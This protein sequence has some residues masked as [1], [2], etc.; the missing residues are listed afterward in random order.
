LNET[1]AAQYG[2]RQSHILYTPLLH[3][4]GAVL[5]DLTLNTV[6]GLAQHIE[7]LAVSATTD[8]ELFPVERLLVND[9]PQRYS[10]QIILPVVGFVARDIAF[11]WRALTKTPFTASTCTVRV[12]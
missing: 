1:T 11:R 3:A 9:G 5:A 8:G 2:E 12:T 10:E 6:S 4:P 7:H